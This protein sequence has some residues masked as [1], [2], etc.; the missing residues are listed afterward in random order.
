MNQIT[1]EDLIIA[2]RKVKVDCFYETGNLTALTFA[3]YEDKL[4]SN[5]NELYDKISNKE[6]DWFKRDAFLGTH[7]FTLKNV[8][9]TEKEKSNEKEQPEDEFIFFSNSKRKWENNNNQ[10]INVDYRIIGNHSVNF[11]I[12]SSL[13]IEKVG[14]KLE[15]NVSE[16]SYGCRIKRIGQ[17]ENDFIPEKIENQPSHISKHSFGT[18]RPYLSDYQKWQ[19]NGIESVKI[20]LNENKKVVAVTADL[21]KYY[22]RIDCTFIQSEDFFKYLNEA[23][24]L[25]E[26][27]L[28]NDLLV[29]SIKSW[30]KM[31]YDDDKVPLEFKFNGHCGVPMS[32]GASKIIANLLLTYLD[33][34]IENEIKPIY[35]GRYVDDIFL[36]IKDGSSI[37]NSNDFWNFMTKRIDNLHR[38]SD[39][40]INQSND[41][42]EYNPKGYVLSIPYSKNSLVE[43]GIGKEKYFFLEGE[44]GHAFL[45]SL[46]DSLDEN[47][48]EWKLPPNTDNDIESY[49]KQIANASKNNNEPA[50]GLRKSD[51]LSIQR[52]KF[53]LNLTKLEKAIELLPK[54]KWESSI[55]DFL[56][57]SIDYLLTPETFGVYAKYFPRLISLAIKAK[58]YNYGK[59]LIESIK[60]S[61]ESIEKSF[62]SSKLLKKKSSSDT[63][64]I[65]ESIKCLESSK[66]YMLNLIYDGVYST[67]NF[68]ENIPDIKKE[69]TQLLNC[70]HPQEVNLFEDVIKKS[71]KL[72]FADLHKIPF[73]E[74]ALNA[75]FLIYINHKIKGFYHTD[76]IIYSIDDLPHYD[77][78]KIFCDW[79]SHN[80]LLNHNNSSFRPFAFYFYTRP[81]TLLELSLLIRDWYNKDNSYFTPFCR[82]FNIEWSK[83][84]L[85][86]IKDQENLNSITIGSPYKELNRVFAFTSLETK[87]ESWIAKVREDGFEPDG[88]REQRI[89]DL[90]SEIIQCKKKIINYVLFPELSIPQK[91]LLYIASLF[92]K[93]QISLIAGIEYRNSSSLNFDLPKGFKGFVTNELIYILCTKSKSSIHQVAL[94]QEKVIPAQKEESELFLV[95]GKILK[96]INENKFIIN[97]GGLWLSGL[98]CNDL[99]DINNRAPLRG[100]IDA[101][102]IV[103]WNKDIDTYDSLVT[104]SAN[105]L[106]AFVLQVNN[107][108]YGDTRLRGPY[109][110]SYDRDKVRVRGGELDYFVVST[111]EVEELRNFQRYHRS[112]ETPFK[113]VPTGF[114]MSE[115]RRNDPR[116]ED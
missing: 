73:K 89:L 48:S 36:V 66:K 58:L 78:F 92:L 14:S 100:I 12:L 26:E 32:L 107:R 56:Q 52:L 57:L 49:T 65:N 108:L 35:Y 90:V 76:R 16:N 99:L 54:N 55:K 71:E 79:I 86:N 59:N 11:H 3:E 88:T 96:T 27:L 15:L 53:I 68:F 5:L 61:F 64:K 40:T 91:L 42:I 116:M 10:E 63:E 102:I 93:K 43:F 112:P 4:L 105:D 94:I 62:E 19:Y 39:N 7:H 69:I 45:T 41:T 83:P 104:S 51:G 31:V 74:V 37:K 113:P 70:I 17:N 20:A 1:I 101:L 18:F 82:L 98:I 25:P 28:I 23:N 87:N 85:K 9:V 75:D 13:W 60:E 81:F 22:H 84:D 47:S 115:E 8:T 33:R 80:F 24:L 44:S 67:F 110:E 38:Y 97:H 6:Y 50:N 29:L 106:H 2:Y 114:I 34:E 103:E 30:S 46:K 21:K 95:G 109:K 72:F 111:L 77:D